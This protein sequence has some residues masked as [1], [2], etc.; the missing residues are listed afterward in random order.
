MFSI[1]LKFSFAVF[2]FELNAFCSYRAL[3]LNMYSVGS[4]VTVNVILMKIMKLE[5]SNSGK[6]QQNWIKCFLHI[7]KTPNLI[8]DQQL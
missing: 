1:F 4:R 2:C 5:S 6:I 7:W 3:V 8:S